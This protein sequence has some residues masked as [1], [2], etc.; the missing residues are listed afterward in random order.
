MLKNLVQHFMRPNEEKIEKKNFLYIGSSQGDIQKLMVELQ[1]SQVVLPRSVESTW[2]NLLAPKFYGFK[3][4]YYEYLMQAL[5]MGFEEFNEGM[6]VLDPS[7]KNLNEVFFARFKK[8]DFQIILEKQTY[9]DTL[10]R[11]A[12]RVV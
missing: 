6:I 8:N 1:I 12:D 2:N 9:N 11:Y 5:R 7:D 10:L 3:V 4:K